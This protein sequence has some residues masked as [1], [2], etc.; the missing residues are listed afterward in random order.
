MREYRRKSVFAFTKSEQKVVDALEQEKDSKKVCEKLGISVGYLSHVRVKAKQLKDI[1][2]DDFSP[3]KA[4]TPSRL[5]SARG[6][7]LGK[8]IG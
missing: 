1:L 2:Q 6:R 4:H 5:K 3:E 8:F 7:S